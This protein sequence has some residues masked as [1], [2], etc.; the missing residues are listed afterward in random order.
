MLTLKRTLSFLLVLTMLMGMI[1][2]VSV[3]AEETEAME[4]A[5][6]VETT[7]IETTEAETSATEVT[8]TEETSVS[9]S[10]EAIEEET[11]A[12]EK[13]EADNIIAEGTCGDELTWTLDAEGT[14][15]ISGT[16]RFYEKWGDYQYPWY[17]MRSSITNVIL[18]DGITYIPLEAFES[19]IR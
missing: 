19:I 7:E 9:E 17:D 13:K 4:E 11:F 2:P 3:R 8:V 6:A 1:L 10:T 18:E 14:L 5:I 16:G 15:T 12:L